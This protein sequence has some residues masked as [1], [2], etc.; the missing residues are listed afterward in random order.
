MPDGIWIVGAII[1]GVAVY[2][3]VKVRHF[4][5]VSNRQWEDVDKSKL[6]AW[7]DDD[8]W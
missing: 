6:K 4:M 3:A 5:R 2:V 8:D 7:E 1:L